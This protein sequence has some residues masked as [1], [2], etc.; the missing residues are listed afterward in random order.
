MRAPIKRAGFIGTLA[1]LFGGALAVAF[2]PTPVPVDLAQADRGD[3]VVTA[4][5]EGRARVR[6]VYVVSAPLTGRLARIGLRVGDPVIAGQTVL[7]SLEEL[8]PTLLDARSRAEADARLQTA[9]AALLLAG[10]EREQVRAQLD[11][12]R[13]ELRRQQELH[14]RGATTTRALEEAQ[15]EVR[16][17]EARLATAEA[18]VRMRQS[19][20]EAARAALIE[21][22]ITDLPAGARC[23]LPLRAPV[24]GT[25]LAILQESETVVQAGTPLVEIGDPRDLEIIVDLP[26]RAAVRVSPG[27]PAVL[28]NWGG[29]P[30]SGTVRRVEPTAFTK[31]SALGIEEQRVNVLLDLDGIPDG[32]AA[33]R[34]RLGHGYRVMVRI[35]VDRADAALRVPVGALF[36]DGGRWALFV[37]ENGR[38]RLIHPEIGLTDGRHAELRSGLAEGATIIL[39]PSDRI[40]DGTRVTPRQN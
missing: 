15:M 28:E 40:D 24:D 39:H 20:L 13:Q 16:T 30:L 27:A 11:F 18:A 10:A 35:T 12:A 3:I 22:G 29:A 34:D 25:V 9:E 8:D 2:W 5:G 4:D 21:P 33:D 6:D 32:A 17:G 26:S 38:A 23:C 7:A 36:R 31:I 37:A 19:E 14:A 1:L